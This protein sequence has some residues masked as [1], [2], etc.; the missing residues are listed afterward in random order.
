M[1][2]LG[3]ATTYCFPFAWS[4]CIKYN[5]VTQKNPHIIWCERDTVAR[6]AQSVTKLFKMIPTS[7]DTLANIT[8]ELVTT[9]KRL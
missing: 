7:I 9:K 2:L 3:R 6:H 1:F 5:S 4:K 8:G